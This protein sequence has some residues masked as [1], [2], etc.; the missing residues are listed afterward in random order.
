MLFTFI[1]LRAIQRNRA[2]LAEIENRALP[3]VDAKLDVE[4]LPATNRTGV[5]LRAT[6][7]NRTQRPVTLRLHSLLACYESPFGTSGELLAWEQD[8]SAHEP[9][10]RYLR[11]LLDA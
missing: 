3:A 2:E 9:L 10:P 4:L 11:V 1:E 6:V 8:L 7:E 5:V